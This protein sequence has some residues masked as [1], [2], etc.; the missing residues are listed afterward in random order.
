MTVVNGWLDWAIKAPAPVEKGRYTN[1]PERAMSE[2][3]YLVMHL[4]GGW[5]AFL[6]RGHRPGEEASWT[7]S[8]CQ[9]GDFYQHYPLSALTFTS[10]GYTQN[11]DGLACENEGMPGWSMNAVQIANAR[12]MREDVKTICPNLR[13]P[14]L[15]AGFREHGEL[16]NGATDCP[17]GAISP[18]YQSYITREEDMALTQEEHGVL[19]NLFAWAQEQHDMLKG[20]GEPDLSG[21]PQPESILGRLAALE[22]QLNTMPTLA[23]D[24]AAIAKAVNDDAA[25]RL[26]E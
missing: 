19:M 23:V 21:L 7:F 6:R 9:D 1:D 4:A 25:A 20:A 5:E 3:L 26:K 18:L 8:N 2:I 12:R 11:R 24:A 16:T 17:S 14:F 10:G 13:P 15:G 22:A